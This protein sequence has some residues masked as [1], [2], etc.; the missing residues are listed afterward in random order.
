MSVTIVSNY[1]SFVDHLLYAYN[2]LIYL[3]HTETFV[4]HQTKIPSDLKI[5]EIKCNNVH[6]R[7]VFRNENTFRLHIVKT[8][9]K[10]G[11]RYHYKLYLQC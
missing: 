4:I 1:S 9:P 3:K 6:L 11:T 7:T 10:T 5:Y 2:N 8:E